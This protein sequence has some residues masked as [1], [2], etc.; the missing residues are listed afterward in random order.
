[1]AERQ[2]G[3]TNIADFQRFEHQINQFN[4]SRHIG[5]AVQFRADLKRLARGQKTF[6]SCMQYRT[7]IAQAVNPLIG[8]QQMR[9]DA[10]HLRRNIRAD[11][12][13]AAAQLVDHPNGF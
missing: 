12:K 6:R 7:G 11:T 8:R 10:R 1:M 3:L 9:I 13:L 2:N 5:I 4:I